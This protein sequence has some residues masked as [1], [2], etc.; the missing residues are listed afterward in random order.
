MK[1]PLRK[2]LQQ[3]AEWLRANHPTPYPVVVRWTPK[4]ASDP[5]DPAELRKIGDFAECY[6]SKGRVI[7]RLSSRRC[8]SFHVASDTLLHEW[9]HAMTM[10]NS[11]LERHPAR[12]HSHHGDDWALAFG[13]CYR[14]WV[15]EGGSDASK[16]I[17]V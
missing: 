2:R 12:S 9:A 11:R 4:I 1:T 3:M 6:W 5:S 7:I 10:P 17:R 13:R 15:D 8:R 14:S 16:K